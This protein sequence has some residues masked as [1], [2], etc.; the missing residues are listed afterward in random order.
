[1]GDSDSGG[2]G[3]LKW[4]IGILVTLAVGAGVPIYLANRG[5]NT[6]P[7]AQNVPITTTTSRSG[8]V[9]PTGPVG[10]TGPAFPDLGDI[11]KPANLYA[12]KTSGPAGSTVLLSG[13]GFKAGEEVVFS[14]QTEEV[15]RTTAD[16]AG[17]FTSVSVKVPLDLGKFPGTQ[18][19]FS[20]DGR[21]SIKHA[22]APFV[23]SG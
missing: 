16:S 10:P 3:W 22:T 8:P 14:M 15:G 9:V 21:T 23:V 19:S 11:A 17:A 2:G 18:F 5:G 4:F 6:T 12:S 1:M 7:E 13:N 20:A